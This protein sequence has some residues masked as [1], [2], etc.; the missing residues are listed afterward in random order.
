MK[1]GCDCVGSFPNTVERTSDHVGFFPDTVERTSDYV[2]L[3]P[4]PLRE[5]LTM[6]DFFPT[7]LREN[8]T[9]SVA[10]YDKISYFITCDGNTVITV[11][12]QAFFSYR[13]S[14]LRDAKEYRCPSERRLDRK[15]IALSGNNSYLCAPDVYGFASEIQLQAGRRCRQ[16][17][18]Y[19]MRGGCSEFLHL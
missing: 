7:P 15:F 10:I 3:S 17:G 19:R 8:P 11:S 13:L 2:G 6:S 14:G 5:R 4:T 9:M 1:K 16:M 12:G 18:L